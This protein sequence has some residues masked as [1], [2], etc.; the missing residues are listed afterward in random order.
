MI[1]STNRTYQLL[2]CYYSQYLKQYMTSV[3][4]TYN[5]AIEKF[6]FHLLAVTEET[7]LKNKSVKYEYNSRSKCSVH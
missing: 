6:W 1:I 7:N 4:V 3:T 5:N 2:I